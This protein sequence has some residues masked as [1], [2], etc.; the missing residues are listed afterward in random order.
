MS[1]LDEIKSGTLDPST[2]DGG[3]E[4]GAN[5]DDLNLQQTN[6]SP[7]VGNPTEGDTQQDK[8]EEGEKSY[9]GR[10]KDEQEAIKYIEEL[11]KNQETLK[12]ELDQIRQS[13]TEK[14]LINTKV[15]KTVGEEEDLNDLLAKAKELF[16]EEQLGVMQKLLDATVKKYISPLTQQLV[17][18]TASREIEEIQ[19]IPNYQKY[20]P[21]VKAVIE[22]NPNLSLVDAF[23]MVAFDDMIKNKNQAQSKEVID[24]KRMAQVEAGGTHL[25]P[26]VVG[27][28]ESDKL[29]QLLGLDKVG[30]G[31]NSLISR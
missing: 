12:Q 3:G 30:L 4:P 24:L 29:V 11:E 22:R 18:H 31:I 19:K 1:L 5:F 15:K 21:A 28:D 27:R 16:D 8:G 20:I 26:S 6:L 13:L 9:L 17:E 14:D 2:N 25:E 10:F 7:D 23:K